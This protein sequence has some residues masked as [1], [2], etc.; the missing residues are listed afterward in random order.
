MANPDFS[1]QQQ[2]QQQPMSTHLRHV[3]S[4]SFRD[5]SVSARLSGSARLGSS[6]IP[7]SPTSV[8]VPSSL[9]PFP[10]VDYFTAIHPPLP[11]SN[12]T[13]NPYPV[14]HPITTRKTHTA[15]HAQNKQNNSIKAFPPYS[16]AQPLSSLRPLPPSRM[17]G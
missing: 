9:S 11:S 2:Q 7:S 8:S 12:V 14:P 1:S 3:S 17:T 16:I 10:F 6:S 13:S 5:R 15:P 4:H